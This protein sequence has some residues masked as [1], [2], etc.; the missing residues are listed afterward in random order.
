MARVDDTSGKVTIQG[1]TMTNVTDA[2]LTMNGED[3]DIT[4]I[5]DSNPSEEDITETFE[6][7]ITANYDPADTAM[8]AIRAKFVGG[9]RTLTSVAYYE[10]TNAGSGYF[11]G[12]ALISSC[13]LTKTVGSFDKFNAT[14][15][16]RGSWS[17]TA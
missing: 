9:S 13:S 10:G 3:W 7:S 12:S 2:T 15:K 5:G 8:A 14:L 11:G 1:S 17:Y 6:L 16:S 4:A